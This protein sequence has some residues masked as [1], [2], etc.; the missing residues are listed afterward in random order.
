[1]AWTVAGA[2]CVPAAVLVF[3]KIRGHAEGLEST[4]IPCPVHCLE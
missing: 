2:A 3:N 1:M 4:S